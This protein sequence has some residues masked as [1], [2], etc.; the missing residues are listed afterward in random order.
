MPAATE[1]TAAV[2]TLGAPTK[3]KLASTV[4]GQPGDQLRD[5]LEVRL[6][7]LAALVGL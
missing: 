6:Q 5:P 7:D 4:C 3:T 1:V 2:S